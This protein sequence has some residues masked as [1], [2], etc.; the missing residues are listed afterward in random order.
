[1]PS[2]SLET[3]NTGVLQHKPHLYAGP[4]VVEGVMG[5]G[6]AFSISLTT[7]VRIGC[8]LKQN[9]KKEINKVGMDV[10]PCPGVVSLK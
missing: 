10:L 4:H 7:C 3:V 6:W 9:A 2:F 5:V 8:S 1:M